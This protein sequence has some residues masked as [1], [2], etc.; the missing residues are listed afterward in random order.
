[1]TAPKVLD[2]EGRPLEVGDRV[3]FDPSGDE[4]KVTTVYLNV[5]SLAGRIGA[6]VSYSPPDALPGVRYH[7]AG[8]TEDPNSFRGPRP[9]PHQQGRGSG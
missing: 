9:H 8:P 1:M 4:G 5:H 3:R 6:G 2:R 7:H